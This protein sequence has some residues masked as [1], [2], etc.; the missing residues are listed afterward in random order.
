MG[1]DITNMTDMTDITNMTDMTD[2]TDMIDI[3]DMT[4]M[5]DMTVYGQSRGC[6]YGEPP[7]KMLDTCVDTPAEMLDT[8][9]ASWRDSWTCLWTS[10]CLYFDIHGDSGKFRGLF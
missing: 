5:T 10:Y 7:V 3:T 1:T 6:V 2:M 9:T 8:R 4:Y